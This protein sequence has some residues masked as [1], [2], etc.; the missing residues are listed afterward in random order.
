MRLSIIIPYFNADAWIG[1]MLDSL[2]DQDIAQDEYEIIIV[3]DDSSEPAVT[4]QDYVSKYPSIKYHRINHAGPSGARNYGIG[5]SEGEW[6]YF[7]DSDDLVQRQVFGDLL[8]IADDRQLE[9]L[10]FDFVLLQEGITIDK[11][12]RELSSVSETLTMWDHI[13]TYTSNPMSFG[14]G[15]W[16]FI[17]KR[18]VL[19]QNSLVFDDLMYVEDRI[20]QLRLIPVVKRVAH[21]DVQVYFYIQRDSSIMHAKKKRNYARFAPWL[22]TYL[23]YLSEM[24]RLPDIPEGARK[25]LICWRDTGVFSLL[26]HCLRYCPY[27]VSDLYL[28]K[29]SSSDAYPLE[30]RETGYIRLTRR[31]MNHPGLWRLL[32]RLYCLIPYRI[33]LL[34]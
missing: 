28:D 14:F 7:C 3:D 33:R 34:L 15:L 31:L 18:E 5:I 29:L 4:L 27:A 10:I 23:S 19:Q 22:W 1:A 11:P 2:L 26:H 20:F 6:I 9:M 30:I 24:I 16:R 8:D 25:V 13:A 12:L 21:I 17:I 32:C